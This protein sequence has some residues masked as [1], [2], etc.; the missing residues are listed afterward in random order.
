MHYA[1]AAILAVRWLQWKNSRS[2]KAQ[3]DAG[4]REAPHNFGNGP[5]APY[6]VLR[7]TPQPRLMLQHQHNQDQHQACPR[8]THHKQFRHDR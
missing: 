5:L 8:Q 6:D 1:E 3:H 4:H 2:H 7:I